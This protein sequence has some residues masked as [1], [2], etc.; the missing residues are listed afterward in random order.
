MQ[1]ETEYIQTTNDSI[2]QKTLYTYGANNLIS[3][4]KTINSHGD[5][6]QT[7]MNYSGNYQ[8]AP[9]TGMSQKFM[10]NYPVEI[11]HFFKNKAIGGNLTMY[12]QVINSLDTMYLP[13]KTSSLETPISLTSFT[14]FNGTTMD[15]HYGTPNLTFLS[16]DARG[17]IREIEDRAGISTTYLWGY[18]YQYPIAAIKNATF[19]QVQSALGMS[20]VDTQLSALGIPDTAKVNALR[21]QLANAMISTYSYQPLIGLISATNPQEVT[22]RYNYDTFGRLWFAW[23]DDKKIFSHY[24]YG[25]QNAPDNGEGGYTTPSAVISVNAS[26]Y[27]LDTTGTATISIS[28]GS[29]NYTYN[30]YLE[31]S[32]G[33]VLSSSL[34]TTS[35][36]FSFTC[37]Q[38][39]T[40][41]VQCVVTD[42]L[43]G[44]SVAFNKT[45]ACYTALSCGRRF[46]QGTTGTGTVTATG[47]SGSYYYSWDFKDSFTDLFINNHTTSTSFSFVCSE[48]G[49]MTLQC[50]VTDNQTGQSVTLTKPITVI[51]NGGPPD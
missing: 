8:V 47:G 2:Q 24:H 20:N 41:T 9:Y 28:G 35:T 6:L 38:T 27:T 7:S 48:A 51:S 42:I 19:S 30:W 16:Y 39:G 3:I 50:V 11:T 45:I 36:S 34:N 14:P 10:I 21:T 26:S 4:M 13:D 23:N 40:L 44:Q 33:A 22:T 17:N 31:T 12:K 1:T 32:S 5:T 29:G 46:T 15:S 43:T 49:S 37:S 25:Y 18:E